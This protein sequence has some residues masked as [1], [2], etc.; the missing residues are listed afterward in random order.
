M[1]VCVFVC[2]YTYMN[3]CAQGV[4]KTLLQIIN[5]IMIGTSFIPVVAK[6]K[7]RFYSCICTSLTN[8]NTHTQRFFSVSPKSQS[9]K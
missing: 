6:R 8:A 7:D 4:K 1:C 2:V 5:E 3:I 9:G